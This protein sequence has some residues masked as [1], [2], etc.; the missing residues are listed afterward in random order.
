MCGLGEGG[1]VKLTKARRRALETLAV[2]GRAQVSN[3]T[4]QD[5]GYV[6]WQSAEWLVA[7]DLAR[8]SSVFARTI[9]ITAAGREA[10]A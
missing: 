1:G 7:N 8:R 4:D 5:A 2:D 9:H 3:V 10:L 6:Y